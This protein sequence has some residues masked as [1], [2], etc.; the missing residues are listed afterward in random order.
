LKANIQIRIYSH[1]FN[2][3]LIKTE[4]EFHTSK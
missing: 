4:I 1:T 3:I 2:L